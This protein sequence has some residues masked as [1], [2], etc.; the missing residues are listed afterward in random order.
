MSEK[1]F[2]KAIKAYFDHELYKDAFITL[3]TLF[4]C[5]CRRGALG[6]AAD[7]CEAAIAA[8][9]EAG[10]ACNREICRAWEELLAAVRVRQLEEAELAAARQY[11]VRNWSVARGGALVLARLEAA[12]EP[13]VQAAPTPPPLP[14]PPAEAV[15]HSAALAAYERQLIEHALQ[16]AEGNVTK[17]SRLLGLSRNGLKSKIQRFGL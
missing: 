8:T 1:L 13:R 7:L 10:E 14:Q 17:A 11:L 3:L 5:F 15:G 2:R 12:V 4:E 9:S 16:Q 6:K